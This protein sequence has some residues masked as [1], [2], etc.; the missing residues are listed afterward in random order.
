MAK[1]MKECYNPLQIASW[2]S[3]MCLK[4]EKSKLNSQQSLHS[5]C[6]QW[7][8]LVTQGKN[9]HPEASLVCIMEADPKSSS[10]QPGCFCNY[11]GVSFFFLSIAFKAQKTPDL[12]P[13]FIS[14][15]CCF[16]FCFKFFGC[17]KI[18]D[19]FYRNN[20]FVREIAFIGYF[21][22]IHFHPGYACLLDM[23]T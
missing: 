17:T 19:S 8:Q 22:F 23:L 21:C 9:T 5:N 11:D 16:C 18:T 20:S 10:A 15:F 2:G 6:T 14:V 13:S 12:Y 4:L 1:K 7:P 3:L